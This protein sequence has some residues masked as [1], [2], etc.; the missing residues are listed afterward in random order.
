MEPIFEWDETKARQNLRKHNISFEEAATVFGDP[1]SVTVPDPRHSE[2]EDRYVV[3]GCSANQRML[4]VVYT[5]RGRSIRVISCRKAT[6]S[7]RKA[8]E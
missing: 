5:V 8:Y 6:R 2:E 4:V 7:E 3:I 1:M